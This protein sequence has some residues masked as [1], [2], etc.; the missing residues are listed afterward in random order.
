MLGSVT[1]P[2][3]ESTH[4]NSGRKRVCQRPHW[5]G[6]GGGKSEKASQSG[7]LQIFTAGRF[8]VGRHA[9]QEASTSRQWVEN[10]PVCGTWEL[11]GLPQTSR[12]S[13]GFLGGVEGKNK[14]LKA[15]ETRDGL[16]C[17]T[18]Q[19]AQFELRTSRRQKRMLKCHSGIPIFHMSSSKKITK[20]HVG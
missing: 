19:K 16:A 2:Q 13:L 12:L 5:G 20:R 9:F 14:N 11:R 18:Q 6:R 7:A 3:Q 8:P 4:S 15:L 10:R 1:G 17:T